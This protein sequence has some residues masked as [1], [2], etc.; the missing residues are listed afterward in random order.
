MP[1]H[2]VG[3]IDGKTYFFSWLDSVERNRQLNWNAARSF[4]KVTKMRHESAFFPT[5]NVNSL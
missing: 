3:L 4:C 1:A 2:R 5:S